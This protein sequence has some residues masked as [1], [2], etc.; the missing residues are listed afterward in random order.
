MKNP[1]ISL[2]VSIVLYALVVILT[3]IGGSQF[4]NS[5][6]PGLAL[7]LSRIMII[8]AIVGILF[9]SVL[10]LIQNPKKSI[11]TLLGLGFLIVLFLITY[12]ASSPEHLSKIQV[13]DGYAK[14]V[15][16]SLSL[17]MITA[18]IAVF[19]IAISEIMALFK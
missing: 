17:L 10:Q 13:S 8:V 9:F 1:K 2:I 3:L 11:P 4:Y 7:G 6:D 19:S 14:F 16:G 12:S 15:G 18:V 5:N